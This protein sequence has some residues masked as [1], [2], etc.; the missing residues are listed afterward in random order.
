MI[1]TTAIRDT[2]SLSTTGANYATQFK[3]I[4]ASYLVAKLIRTSDDQEV[5][6]SSGTDYVLSGVG[7]DT[8][9]ISLV[10][11]ETA[12][13]VTDWTTYDTG[14]WQLLLTL[15]IPIL[16]SSDYTINGRFSEELLE[17][18]LDKI[19]QIIQLAELGIDTT[20]SSLAIAWPDN[21]PSG[22]S[23]KLPSQA[24]RNGKLAGWDS[25]TGEWEAV[26][27]DADNLGGMTGPATQV[28]GNLAIYSGVQGSLTQQ[29]N[30]DKSLFLSQTLVYG[31]TINWDS[32]LGHIA[33][34]NLS[35][36]PTL[37]LTNIKPGVYKLLVNQDVTGGRTIT[38]NTGFG[39]TN[40]VAL[41]TDSNGFSSLAFTSD[42]T[43]VY[44]DG[45]SSAAQ[46][47]AGL[48][49][50]YQDFAYDISAVED[51]IGYLRCNGQAV[52]KTKYADLY[53]VIGDTY[54]TTAQT[55]DGAN[56]TNF[57]APSGSEFRLPNLELSGYGAFRRA[58]ATPGI[59][60]TDSTA[61][62]GLGISVSDSGH[63]HG[64]T[65]GGGDVNVYREQVA[66]TGTPDATIDDV[67]GDENQG[68]SPGD[69]S[70][71]SGNANI[72]SSI[73]TEDT[74]TAPLNISCMVGIKF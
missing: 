18:D 31:A 68:Q 67:Y 69:L 52:S 13:N 22:T 29:T 27:L 11:Y 66:G 9:S 6:L 43:T 71:K 50:T 16:Q 17:N 10:P 51:D 59:V 70:I 28:E 55:W 44:F 73:N 46:A 1:G 40:A 62:N 26:D 72:S 20:G 56:F 39:N 49:G 61:K 21:E 57:S 15:N 30:I 7:N 5:V 19:I 36:N 60:T 25:V 23:G 8:A 47:A 14:P 38:F 63:T 48:V 64:F 58:G 54:A 34:L 53:A 41:N 2:F 45:S 3:V 24:E 37:N 74:E 33:T 35:G 42:G 65:S 4:A 32:S 12:N